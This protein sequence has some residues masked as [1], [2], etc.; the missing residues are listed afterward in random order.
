MVAAR[1]EGIITADVV[2][3][4]G[5]TVG[6]M[7]KRA[8]Q[9][10]GPDGKLGEPD[11]WVQLP[12]SSGSIP[13]ARGRTIRLIFIPNADATLDAEDCTVVIPAYNNGIRTTLTKEDFGMAVGKDYAAPEVKKGKENVIGE[14]VLEAGDNLQF[15]GGI[16]YVE[17]KD[18]N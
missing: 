4:E 3:K 10:M 18:N 17:L 6:L 5:G 16:T 13:G 11:K 1:V 14:K 2:R 12:R 9:E 8:T 7:G 15:G